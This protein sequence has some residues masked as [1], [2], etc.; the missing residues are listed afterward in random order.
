MIPRGSCLRAGLGFIRVCVE[1][2][3]S[4]ACSVDTLVLVKIRQYVGVLQSGGMLCAAMLH[5]KDCVATSLYFVSRV[6]LA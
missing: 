2:R 6:C 4:R 1:I 5:W 3:V